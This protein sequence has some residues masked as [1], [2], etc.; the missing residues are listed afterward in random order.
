MKKFLII[1]IS[2]IH[3]VLGTSFAHAQSF[4]PTDGDFSNVPGVGIDANDIDIDISPESPTAF[5]VVT[6][7]LDSNII[8]L[9]RTDISWYVNGS[10][11]LSGTGQRS[12][13]T[14]I[15]DYGSI[16]DVA[17][18]VTVGNKVIQK[19]I[20]LSPADIVMTYQALDAYAPPFYPGKR[21][22]PTE[23]VIRIVAMPN[24]VSG[25]SPM[26]ISKGVYTWKRNK[27]A[28]PGV[29]GYGKNYITV[30]ND[31]LIGTETFSVRASD[32]NNTVHGEKTFTFV[33][34]N[35]EIHFYQKIWNQPNLAQA[36]DGGFTMNSKNT[37]VVAVP[38]FFS[39][40]NSFW[41]NTTINWSL[42]GT[43]L[44]VED[45]KNPLALSLEDPGEPGQ[46]TL[47]LTMKHAVNI[48]QET[49]KNFTVVF[50]NR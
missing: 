20:D 1:F 37:T 31:K 17:V 2:I 4:L 39:R 32:I 9:N 29:G 22:A 40:D 43:P 34:R 18:R 15:G 21:I 14:K 26:N 11:V 16:N 24:F 6:L 13:T 42:N 23:G 44:I 49:T 25:G 7:R 10:G 30:K 5:E 33:P 46:N 48:F 36:L 50:S 3:I 8:D 12:L 47:E 19:T 45:I 41:T 27:K 28:L 38:Y 35:P